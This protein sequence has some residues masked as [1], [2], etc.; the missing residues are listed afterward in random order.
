MQ[1]FTTIDLAI[2]EE[3]KLTVEEPVHYA[4]TSEF[5]EDPDIARFV[6]SK[7]KLLGDA[8]HSVIATSTEDLDGRFVS[9]RT[10][11]TGLGNFVCDASKCDL[12]FFF[13]VMIP[14]W[15]TTASVP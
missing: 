11:E 12:F 13:S 4:V 7:L 2:T 1:N 5:T 15:E 10:R 8:R 9:I 14:V 6:A 3:G